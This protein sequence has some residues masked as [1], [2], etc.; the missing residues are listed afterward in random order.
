V[1]DSLEDWAAFA[2]RFHGLLNAPGVQPGQVNQHAFDEWATE[3]DPYD[4][5][6]EA[7]QFVLHLWSSTHPWVCGPFVLRRAI[8]CWDEEHRAVFATWARVPRTW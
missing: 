7:A 8:E 4:G 1:M 5:V 3:Q 2:R 6:R